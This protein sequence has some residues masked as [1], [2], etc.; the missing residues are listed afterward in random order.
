MKNK[1]IVKALAPL[2]CLFLLSSSNAIAE[3]CNGDFDCD[4]CHTQGIG[5]P[6]RCEECHDDGRRYTPHA[7][8]GAGA[9]SG[10]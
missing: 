2:I 8:F 1:S 3:T 7:S 10:N 5:T 4:E 9:E 6:A